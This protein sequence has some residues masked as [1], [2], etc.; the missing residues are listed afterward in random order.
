MLPCVPGGTKVPWH[1]WD[2]YIKISTPPHTKVKKGNQTYVPGYKKDLM[3]PAFQ[4]LIF[5]AI[6]FKSSWFIKMVV[7][8]L[9]VYGIGDNERALVWAHAQAGWRK[10]ANG[11]WSLSILHLPQPMSPLRGNHAICS[12]LPCPRPQGGQGL[13]WLSQEAPTTKPQRALIAEASPNTSPVTSVRVLQP[14]LEQEPLEAIGKQIPT[15]YAQNVTPDRIRWG[16]PFL[17]Q[18]PACNVG[19]AL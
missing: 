17:K 11:W 9:P 2:S 10:Q 8:S 12:I 3:T 13:V 6:L 5:C 15:F 18:A 4:Y 14:D 19:K 16:R 1:C 7:R